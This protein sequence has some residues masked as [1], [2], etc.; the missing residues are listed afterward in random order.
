[1]ESNQTEFNT[2]AFADVRKELTTRL[3]RSW[4][5]TEADLAPRSVYQLVT[6][7]HLLAGH[8][9]YVG[10]HTVTAYTLERIF[11]DSIYDEPLIEPKAEGEAETELKPAVVN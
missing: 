2:V 5:F 4:N 3:V 7:I 6:L 8:R 1:M 10:Q 11:G 9:N